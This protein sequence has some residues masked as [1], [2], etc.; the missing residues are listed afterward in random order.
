MLSDHGVHPTMRNQRNKIIWKGELI[1][2]TTEMDVFS[3]LGMKYIKP[4]DRGV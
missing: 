2:C 4:E 3:L 1:P